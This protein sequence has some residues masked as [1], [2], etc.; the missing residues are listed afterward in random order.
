MEWNL[1]IGLMGI[2]ITILG[3][4]WSL[5]AWLSRQFSDL[6]NLVF[7]ETKKLRDEIVQKIEYH[8]RHDDSRFAQIR[9]DIWEIRISNAARDGLIKPVRSKNE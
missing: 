9:D 8:E 6:R 3:A 1:A 2:A 5:G 7:T 4:E